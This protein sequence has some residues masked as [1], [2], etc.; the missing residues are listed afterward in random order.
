MKQTQHPLTKALIATVTIADLLSGTIALKLP[1]II[2]RELGLAN[3]QTAYVA[4]AADRLWNRGETT[5]LSIALTY[6]VETKE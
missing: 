4:I 2:P 3:P 5:F 1:I 6:Y